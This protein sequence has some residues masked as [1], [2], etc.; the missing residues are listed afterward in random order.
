VLA[1][2]ELGSLLR[3]RVP[4]ETSPWPAWPQVSSWLRALSGFFFFFEVGWTASQDA[5]RLDR[6]NSDRRLSDGLKP[7]EKGAV[8][9]GLRE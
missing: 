3:K 4:G 1:H 6:R 9:A 8:G 2:P 7:R 5:P